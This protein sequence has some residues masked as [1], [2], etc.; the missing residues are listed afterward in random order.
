[1]NLR[2]SSVILMRFE[3]RVKFL[4]FP[5]AVAPSGDNVG[6]WCIKW[7]SSRIEL[8][9]RYS[10]NHSQVGLG[11]IPWNLPSEITFD[12]CI[13]GNYSESVSIKSQGTFLLTY[14]M[15]MQYVVGAGYMDMWSLLRTI[16][17]L[18]YEVVPLCS[19]LWNISMDQG[20]LWP[21]ISQGQPKVPIGISL[22]LNSGLEA[23]TLT[24]AY[25]NIGQ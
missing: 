8:L 6:K 16:C 22:E 15:W 10:I 2:Q 14:W 20:R 12:A 13:Q 23:G 17:E 21:R 25:M 24:W 1:M 3:P 9:V 7:V 11:L 5:H 4:W 19:R 18:K